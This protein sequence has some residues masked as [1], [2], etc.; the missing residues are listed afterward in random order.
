MGGGV[1]SCLHRRIKRCC[2]VHFA[3]ISPGSLPTA[4]LDPCI[5]SQTVPHTVAAQNNETT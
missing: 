5:R 3:T 1:Y 4:L 2:C